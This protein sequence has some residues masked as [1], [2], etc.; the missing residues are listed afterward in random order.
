LHPFNSGVVTFSCRLLYE[1]YAPPFLY[2][3]NDE[4]TRAFM[5]VHPSSKGFVKYTHPKHTY[6]KALAVDSEWIAQRA[7]AFKAAREQERKA[8][9]ARAGDDPAAK[10]RALSLPGPLLSSSAPDT[11]SLRMRITPVT[12]MA[13]LF[14]LR[15]WSDMGL[16]RV[17]LS[18][19]DDNDQLYGDISPPITLDG[20]WSDE[21]TLAAAAVLWPP[22]KAFQ[23]I[24][25]KEES[26][27]WQAPAPPPCP[28][29]TLHVEL[30]TPQAFMIIG[31]AES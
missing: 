26:S 20:T 12:H 11:P 3:W 6:K 2:V 5:H 22:Q 4:E 25:E 27:N 31:H 7:P 9:L 30:L 24:G 19:R 13:L 15:S 21:A 10:E 14:Y 29:N 18:C 23:G 28:F 16:A 8:A 1:P 17:W